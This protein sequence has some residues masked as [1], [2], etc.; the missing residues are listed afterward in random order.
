MVQVENYANVIE[1]VLNAYK[2]Q[3]YINAPSVEQQLIINPDKTQFLLVAVG[4]HNDIY[5]HYVVFHLQI[6]DNKVWL[7]ENRTDVDIAQELVDNGIPK[8]SIILGF[9]EALLRVDSGYAHA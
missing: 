4:W 3:R 6:R 5:T 1:S 2:E 7:H 9:V 8:S